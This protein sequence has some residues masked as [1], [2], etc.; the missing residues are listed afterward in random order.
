MSQQK[1]DPMRTRLLCTAVLVAAGLRAQ[2]Q[3][4]YFQAMACIK[5]Q[6]GKAAEYRQFTADVTTK[7]QQARLDS[8]E[9]STWTLLRSVYPAG[10]EARCDY[11]SSTVTEGSPREP[12][13]REG[14]AE[15]LK[16]AGLKMTAAEYVARRDSLSRLVSSELWRMRIRVGRPQKGTTST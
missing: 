13:G 16:K 1:G 12:L 10:G 6:P 9:I 4:L 7:L 11:L 5:L 14:L 2:Q 3:P 8:G 15:A